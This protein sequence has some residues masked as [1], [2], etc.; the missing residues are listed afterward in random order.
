MRYACATCCELPSNISTMVFT[1]LFSLCFVLP[2]NQLVM[3]KTKKLLLEVL[4][5]LIIFFFEGA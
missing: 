1:L 4:K 5:I 2:M 3:G